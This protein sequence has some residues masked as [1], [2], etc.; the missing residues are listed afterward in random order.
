M[1]RA[2]VCDPAGPRWWRVATTAGT[3][4]A[5]GSNAHGALG[6]GTGLNAAS[7]VQV[8]GLSGITQVAAGF[9]HIILGLPAPYPDNVARWVADKIIA[10][11]L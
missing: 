1:L 10:E 6:T 9:G 5:W 7:P 8:P 2:R 3:V 11:S 4:F